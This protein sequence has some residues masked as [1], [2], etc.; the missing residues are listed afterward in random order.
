M[1]N[2][3]LEMWYWT[4]MLGVFIGFAIYYSYCFLRDLWIAFKKRMADSDL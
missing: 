3:I 1:I 2:N 4:L